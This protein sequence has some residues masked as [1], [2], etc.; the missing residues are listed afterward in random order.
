M[1][2]A[3]AELLVVKKDE[4][5]HYVQL[6]QNDAKYH[7][8]IAAVILSYQWPMII[9]NTKL[10]SQLTQEEQS[11]LLSSGS[12]Y[13]CA[14]E[15]FIRKKIQEIDASYDVVFIPTSLY[16]ILTLHEMRNNN[17]LIQTLKNK[18]FP[19]DFES[20]AQGS[21]ESVHT[22]HDREYP[23]LFFDN[24]NNIVHFL[25][26][27]Y[28][29]FQIAANANIMADEIEMRSQEIPVVAI[30]SSKDH[31]SNKV[32]RNR[33]PLDEFLDTV[34]TDQTSIFYPYFGK[35]IASNKLLAQV[36]AIEYQA[37]KQNKA[38]LLRTNNIIDIKID[39]SSEEVSCLATTWHSKA[40]NKPHANSF[41]NSLFAGVVNDP[42]ACVYHLSG[43]YKNTFGLFLDKKDYIEKGQSSDLLLVSP[44]S[45]IMSL[46]GRNE[47]FHSHS[48]VALAL[49]GEDKTFIS[50][51]QGRFTADSPLITKTQDPFEHAQ[52]FSDYLAKNARILI[53]ED[54][55]SNKALK[56]NHNKLA[57]QYGAMKIMQDKKKAEEDKKKSWF[58]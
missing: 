16:E 46:G 42:G 37:R 40:Y 54:N 3:H 20:L 41:G 11:E 12:E 58:W 33:V 14:E 30:N 56:T 26:Q 48:K 47:W 34:C 49:Q 32:C 4:K 9:A 36:M 27:K 52:K 8:K 18:A 19:L 17:K 24:N 25:F 1:S 38:L 51:V 2:V 43:I 21:Y 29:D 45:S 28:P 53:S 35:S 23:D 44:V 10:D 31:F 7:K 22:I 6:D 5:G 55:F 57:I 13:A 39:D 15:R 50:G